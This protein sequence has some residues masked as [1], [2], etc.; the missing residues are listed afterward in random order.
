MEEEAI[1]LG[2]TLAEQLP[3]MMIMIV[4]V[5][6]FLWYLKQEKKDNR[7][8]HEAQ[9]ERHQ[10]HLTDVSTTFTESLERQAKLF[11]ERA[12]ECHAIQN[13]SLDVME[14]TTKSTTELLTYI[15]ARDGQA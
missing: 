10:Q 12:D 9:A 11:T 14:E 15:K 1:G 6:L 8:S 2:A 5:A 13:R 3:G 4:G 7:Q